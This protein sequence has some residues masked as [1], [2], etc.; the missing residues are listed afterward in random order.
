MA[1]ASS[2][3]V[4]N[5]KLVKG[6][7][8]KEM[9]EDER[10]VEIKL[11]QVMCPMIKDEDTVPNEY[12]D[13]WNLVSTLEQVEKFSRVKQF[14]NILKLIKIVKNVPGEKIDW[15]LGQWEE[16]GLKMNKL[17]APFAAK[18]A[19]PHNP[20]A[21]KQFICTSFNHP[22]GHGCKKKSCVFLHTCVYCDGDDHG[23]HFIEAY[24]FK[25]QSGTRLRCE[26]LRGLQEE[27]AM[28]GSRWPEFVDLVVDGI[29][30]F[31][32]IPRVP[33]VAAAAAAAPVQAPIPVPVPVPTP[34]T[35]A[36]QQVVTPVVSV[37][38]VPVVV[39][40]PIAHPNKK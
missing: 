6:G 39:E 33:V 7:G 14:A 15:Q 29:P 22:A 27:V 21:P 16:H 31:Q 20:H 11:L 26:F 36:P 32:F 8:E 30:M 28:M 34:T 3:K 4:V 38:P 37:A 12:T 1:T 25:N 24:T 18:K 35:P 2:R 23:G 17:A 19:R 10:Q 9:T 13:N 40:V 5:R